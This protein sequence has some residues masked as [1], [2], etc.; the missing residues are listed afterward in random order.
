ML[1]FSVGA[2]D[3]AKTQS[4]KTKGEKSRFIAKHRQSNAPPKHAPT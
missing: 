4:R 1:G 3:A 2:A